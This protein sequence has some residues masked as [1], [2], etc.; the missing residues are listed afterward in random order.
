[1]IRKTESVIFIKD[2]LSNI[3]ALYDKYMREWEKALNEDIN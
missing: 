3:K 1:M 2:E